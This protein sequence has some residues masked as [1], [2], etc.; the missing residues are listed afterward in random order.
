MLLRSGAWYGPPTT[1]HT[2]TQ[3][4]PGC[5]WPLWSAGAATGSDRYSTGGL[6]ERDGTAQRQPTGGYGLTV[7]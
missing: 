3:V 5:S 6:G 4:A 1:I 7:K 2:P